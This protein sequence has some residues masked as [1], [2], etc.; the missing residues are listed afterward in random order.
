MPTIENNNCDTLHEVY[1]RA[2]DRLSYDSDKQ[3][4][5]FTNDEVM[6]CIAHELIGIRIVL[7]R[8]IE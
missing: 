3:P 5:P 2:D 7:E 1:S 6:Q 4:T 8:L